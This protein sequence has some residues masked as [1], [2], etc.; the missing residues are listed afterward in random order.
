MFLFLPS[1]SNASHFIALVSSGIEIEGEEGE[2]GE[3]DEGKEG[4]MIRRTMRTMI[5]Q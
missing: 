2:V 1:F 3:M 4:G 5:E